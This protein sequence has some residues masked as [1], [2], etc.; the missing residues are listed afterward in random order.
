MKRRKS[1][2]TVIVAATAVSGV[3]L[4][5]AARA[6]A[7]PAPEVEYVYNVMVRRHYNFPN[8]DALAY[9]HGICDKV[10]GGEGYAQLMGDVKG[11]VTPSDEFAANYLV[12]YA[13][14]LLCPG[15]I[16]QLRNSAG[17]YQPPG[18]VAGPSTYY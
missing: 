9:G 3:S 13:V 18:G 14:S 5:L 7:V 8:N 1:L 12:S 10:G 17:G 11:D 16:W 15:L 4:I 6:D 2:A